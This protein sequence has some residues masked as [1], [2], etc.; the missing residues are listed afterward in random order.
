MLV[1]QYSNSP[2]LAADPDRAVGAMFKLNNNVY[3]LSQV[4]RNEELYATSGVCAIQNAVVQKF[5]PSTGLFGN[6]TTTTSDRFINA[7][8]SVTF[9]FD[10]YALYNRESLVG[11]HSGAR[12]VGL[13]RRRRHSYSR[14]TSPAT[15]YHFQINSGVATSPIN[16]V[17]ERSVGFI[18]TEGHSMNETA[19]ACALLGMYPDFNYITIKV[20]PYMRRSEES[21]CSVAIS[22]SSFVSVLS[23]ST[24]GSVANLFVRY[25]GNPSPYSFKSV[26]ININITD[27]VVIVHAEGVDLALF[28]ACL[29]AASP[30]SESGWTYRGV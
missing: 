29:E 8:S 28:L 7:L 25:F 24:N 26:R 5:N 3:R 14:C 2:A 15:A 30:A 21:R 27:R 17:E 12:T 23:P 6:A 22:P 11:S 1:Q 19:F 16:G 13:I 4:R 9:P 18:D 20:I 10:P